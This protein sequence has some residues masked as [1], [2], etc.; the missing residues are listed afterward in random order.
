VGNRRRTWHLKARVLHPSP[1]QA[2]RQGLSAGPS[3]I[4]CPLHWK[5]ELP[6]EA[7]LQIRSFSSSGFEGCLEPELHSPAR[8][9]LKGTLPIRSSMGAPNPR[10]ASKT[11]CSGA[12]GLQTY[13]Y[14]WSSRKRHP[15]NL[16]L[17]RELRIRRRP[18]AIARGILQIW[19]SQE[20]SGFRGCLQRELH[21][22]SAGGILKGPAERPPRSGLLTF[23]AGGCL[24]NEC[25]KVYTALC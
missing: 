10:A 25:S 4:D 16:E 14:K 9:R 12:A 22:E 20:S 19:S 2:A 24:Q 18:A 3:Q 21:V 1:L 8:C 5:M 17:S 13:K 15:P 7:R 11:G 6:L 23:S